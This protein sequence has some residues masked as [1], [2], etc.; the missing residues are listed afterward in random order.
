MG[1]ILHLT[2]LLPLKLPD[3]PEV[4]T[5]VESLDRITTITRFRTDLGHRL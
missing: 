1:V 4:H 3:L 5:V 2:Y